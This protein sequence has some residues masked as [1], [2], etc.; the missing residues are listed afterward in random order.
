MAAL[1]E[2]VVISE[3]G[4]KM[5]RSKVQI[6]ALQ[7][8]NKAAAGEYRAIELLAKHTDLV[9]A[10]LVAPQADTTDRSFGSPEDEQILDAFMERLKEGAS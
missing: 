4:R 3:N 2:R 10:E 9:K 6:A 1:N 8:A 5:R 7:I